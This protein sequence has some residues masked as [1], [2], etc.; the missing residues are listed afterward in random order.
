MMCDVCGGEAGYTVCPECVRL[1]ARDEVAARVK[2]LCLKCED[3]VQAVQKALLAV[4]DAEGRL[5]GALRQL[6][7]DVASAIDRLQQEV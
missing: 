7:G 4:F 6:V 1:V 3:E 2:S 5:D